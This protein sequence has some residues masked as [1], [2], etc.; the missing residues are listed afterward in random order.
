MQFCLRNSAA[1]SSG[2]CFT[3]LHEYKHWTHSQLYWHDKLTNLG[4]LHEPKNNIEHDVYRVYRSYKTQ[5]SSA[6]SIYCDWYWGS[7]KSTFLFREHIAQKC[8]LHLLDKKFDYPQ[9][10]NNSCSTTVRSQFIPSYTFTVPL[11]Q[12]RTNL[13]PNNEAYQR[14]FSSRCRCCQ[15][16]I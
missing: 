8:P 14:Y 3:C 9:E 5:I 12:L 6:T 7:S 10:R 2:L 16:F 13:Q 1:L 15:L 11:H 4:V